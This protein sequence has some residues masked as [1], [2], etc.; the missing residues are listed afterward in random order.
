MNRSPG[1][2]SRLSGCRHLH[3]STSI[4][5][6]PHSSPLRANIDAGTTSA[7]QLYR[8]CGDNDITEP[9]PFPPIPILASNAIPDVARSIEDI[10][11][12]NRLAL[13][14]EMTQRKGTEIVSLSS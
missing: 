10:T 12:A 8:F 14:A 9:L 11:H 13:Q 5:S 7:A 1:S 2:P 3:P 6:Q 4:A